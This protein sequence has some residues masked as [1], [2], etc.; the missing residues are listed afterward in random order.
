VSTDYNTFRKLCPEH[1]KAT[2]G[3][4]CAAL[5]LDLFAYWT[6]VRVSNNEQA[7]SGGKE[8][9]DLWFYRS[10][11]DLHSDL[12]GAF[13]RA[14][15]R[16]ALQ[17]L[18]DRGLIESRTNPQSPWD[19][20]L[21]YRT[22][23]RSESD[24]VHDAEPNDDARA[25]PSHPSDARLPL[26]EKGEN[27]RERAP[28]SPSSNGRIGKFKGRPVPSALVDRAAAVLALY[29]DI[30]SRALNPFSGAG[31]PA[32]HLTQIL[33]KVLEHP[34][35]TEADFERVLRA[36]HA[37]PPGFLDGQPVG[38]GDIFGPRAWT[39]A[40]ENPGH[41]AAVVPSPGQPVR[42]DRYSDKRQR[43][44]EREEAAQR[45]LAAQRLREDQG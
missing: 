25:R 9:N 1:L 32:P 36:V 7:A 30:F 41:R 14:A 3:N 43:E 2:G 40:L 24:D 21:Q 34:D 16:T 31:E 44:I 19:R 17:L 11:P 12:Y 8:G 27:A 28:I 35:M 10:L 23:H 33:G 42:H 37:N 5:L 13:G 38:L 15:I 6:Q 39:R 22:L 26:E 18:H 20:T 29:N 45:V 4:A